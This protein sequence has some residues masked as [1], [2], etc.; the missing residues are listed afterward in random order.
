MRRFVLIGGYQL[1]NRRRHIR[2]NSISQ[3]YGNSFLNVINTRSATFSVVGNGGKVIRLF[4]IAHE[5]EV[6]NNLIKEVLMDLQNNDE[7]IE[8]CSGCYSGFTTDSEISDGIWNLLIEGL[9]WYLNPL[10][11]PIAAPNFGITEQTQLT[12]SDL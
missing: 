9:L 10:T 7:G 8:F 1:F 11:P 12:P 3:N 6:S 4:G 2:T 5:S